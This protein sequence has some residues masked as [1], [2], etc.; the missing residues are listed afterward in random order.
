MIINIY[1]SANLLIIQE[2]QFVLNY[3]IV[4]KLKYLLIN[5]KMKS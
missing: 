3:L 1:D 2:K 4:T 5:L